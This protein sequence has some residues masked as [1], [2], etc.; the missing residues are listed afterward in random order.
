MGL[1]MPMREF[2]YVCNINKDYPFWKNTRVLT[3]E[4]EKSVWVCGEHYKVKSIEWVPDRIRE[5]R[6]MFKND[7]IQPFRD[8]QLSKEFV[9][10]YGTKNLDV[11][12]KEVR[13]AKN[14]WQD[15]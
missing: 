2:C 5:E 9:D 11:T 15:L 13:N 8:G 12:D 6:K 14:V 4:G 3:Q 1:C 10:L 7:L